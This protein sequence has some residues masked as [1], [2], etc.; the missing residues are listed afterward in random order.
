M[1]A[2][3]VAVTSTILFLKPKFVDFNGIELDVA[4]H[5]SALEINDVFH[6][7]LSC[8]YFSNLFSQI[9]FL[10]EQSERKSIKFGISGT[11]NIPYSSPR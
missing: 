4:C 11:L 9:P 8:N 10:I 1:G 7:I 3:A 2:T 6:C 5:A